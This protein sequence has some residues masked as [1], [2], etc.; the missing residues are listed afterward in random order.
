MAEV[1]YV[2]KNINNIDENDLKQLSIGNTIANFDNTYYENKKNILQK[3]ENRLKKLLVEIV[4]TY[5][6]KRSSRKTLEIPSVAVVGY[7][8]CGKTS[9]IKAL[10]HDPN[11]TPQNRLF[12]TLDVTT[13]QLWLPSI[14]MNCLMIDT[15]GFISD[16]PLSFVHCFNSTLKE[17]CTADLLIHVVD[18]SNPKHRFQIDIVHQTLKEI[19]VPEKLLNTMIKVFNKVDK[20]S[21]DDLHNCTGIP[22]SATKRIGLDQLISMIEK[23]LIKNTDRIALELK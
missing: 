3:L 4:N 16:I 19:K 13:H 23:R 14:K 11:L 8:N 7:T 22:I 1:D 15:I 10:T 21:E 18:I 12:A 5:N 17:I 6:N 2:R 20:T 9:L